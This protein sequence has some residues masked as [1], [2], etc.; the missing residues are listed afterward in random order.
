VSGPEG[1]DQGRGRSL[2]SRILDAILEGE[3][4]P[5]ESLVEVAV[6]RRFGVSRT[7]VREALRRLEQ[8][9]LVRRVERGM[10]VRERSPEEILDIYEARIVLESSAARAAAQRHTPFDRLR[11][12]KLLRACEEADRADESSLVR[13]NRDFHRGVW[14]AS[15][16]ETLRDLLDRLNLHLLRYPATTLTHEGR[17]EEALAQHAALVEAIAARDEEEAARVAAEHFTAARDIRLAQ[18]T[19]STG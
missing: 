18:W 15:H 6:A 12:D 1:E 5:G 14:E 2:Y 8:D 7:P 13:R 10:V 16:N 17:W 9:G 19:T 3:F 4:E 11:L